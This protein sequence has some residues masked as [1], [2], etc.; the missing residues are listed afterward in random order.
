MSIPRLQNSTHFLFIDEE[1]SAAMERYNCVSVAAFPHSSPL[2][3][4]LS[5]NIESNKYEI[6][7][8]PE[9]KMLLASLY[10]ES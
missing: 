10:S 1:L 7:P 6:N 5:F 3:Y 2:I 4:G 9:N 8:C